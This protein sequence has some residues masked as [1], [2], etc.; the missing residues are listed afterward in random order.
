MISCIIPTYLKLACNWSQFIFK[1]STAISK[2]MF[3]CRKKYIISQSQN[4][5]WQETIVPLNWN[6]FSRLCLVSKNEKGPIQTLSPAPISSHTSM[7]C[8]HSISSHRLPGVSD[9]WPSGHCPLQSLWGQ[10]SPQAR[11]MSLHWGYLV[12]VGQITLW[13]PDLEDF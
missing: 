12:Q 3:S 13:H 11:M 10:V 8:T 7:K 6:Q 2:Q 4:A 9:Q 1:A 5:N